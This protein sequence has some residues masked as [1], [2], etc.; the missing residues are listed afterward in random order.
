MD[1]TVPL[2]IHVIP[3]LASYNNAREISGT[4]VTYLSAKAIDN[5]NID[6]APLAIVGDLGFTR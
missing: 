2:F 4:G 5:T 1:E 3:Y 6:P